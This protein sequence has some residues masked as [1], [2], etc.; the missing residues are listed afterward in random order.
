MI[1][2]ELSLVS[3]KTREKNYMRLGKDSRTYLDHAHTTLS[4]S[5]SYCEASMKA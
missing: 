3:P 5:G 4:R 1:L 2:G